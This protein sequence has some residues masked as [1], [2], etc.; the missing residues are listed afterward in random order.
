MNE[1]T[2]IFEFFLEEWSTTYFPNVEVR[3]YHTPSDPSVGFVE[4]FDIELYLGEKSIWQF[5]T[6]EE[7]N[8]VE[9]ACKSDLNSMK[10]DL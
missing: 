10:D 2:G 7:Q 3:Y 1:Y 8:E 5:L 6:L 9:Q 4:T